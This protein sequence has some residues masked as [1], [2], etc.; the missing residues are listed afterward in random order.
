MKNVEQP[1][2]EKKER[3]VAVKKET[4]TRRADAPEVDSKYKVVSKK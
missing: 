1:Q 4:P 2:E 3:R